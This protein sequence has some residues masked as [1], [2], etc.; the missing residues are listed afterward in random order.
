MN[1]GQS[2]SMAATIIFDNVLEGFSTFTI[3]AKE[4]ADELGM[5]IGETTSNVFDALK[6]RVTEFGENVSNFAT[7]V[8]DKVTEFGMSVEEF[9]TNGYNMAKNSFQV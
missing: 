5:K 1:S 8:K 4:N 2:V 3:S 9:V 6:G 7:T